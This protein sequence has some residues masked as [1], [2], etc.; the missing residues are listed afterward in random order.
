MVRKGGL[1][2]PRLT[3]PDPKSGASANSA[4][5]AQQDEVRETDPVTGFIVNANVWVSE[6]EKRSEWP[7]MNQVFPSQA[8]CRATHSLLLFRKRAAQRNLFKF[9]SS[10][11]VR[12]ACM[13]I[14]IGG[15]GEIAV[16][17]RW[18]PTPRSSFP[19][20]GAL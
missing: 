14:N 9:N 11:L 20:G 17:L 15:S 1:E 18:C 16:T 5:F 3:A 13:L 8:A 12:F 10:A 4:T 6:K 19:R 7:G 2:P